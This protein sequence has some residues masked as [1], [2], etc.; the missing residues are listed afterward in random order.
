[1][2]HPPGDWVPERQE[3]RPVAGG[4]LPQTGHTEPVRRSALG[5][6][7]SG[8]TLSDRGRSENARRPA[9]L[10]G[11]RLTSDQGEGRADLGIV[12]S[13]FLVGEAGRTK[14]GGWTMGCRTWLPWAASFPFFG[15]LDLVSG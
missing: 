13:L 3:P 7:I 8:I 5:Y 10:R 1:M 12:R 11:R 15:V 4:D 2:T 6:A 9:V 14:A